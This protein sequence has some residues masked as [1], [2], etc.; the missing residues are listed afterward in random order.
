LNSDSSTIDFPLTLD[1][2]G[3]FDNF[4]ESLN[5][6]TSFTGLLLTVDVPAD[7]TLFDLYDG[8]FEIDGGRDGN[9]GSFLDSVNFHIEAVP[10][11]AVPEPGNLVLALMGLAGMAAM[12]RRKRRT[13]RRD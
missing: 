5:P 2:S 4:P 1:D 3:F 13:E 10:A 11:S 8:Y 7:V 6:G 9:A 12:L